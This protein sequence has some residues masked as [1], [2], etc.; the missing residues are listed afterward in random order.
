MVRS[1]KRLASRTLR[2][3]AVVIE[4]IQRA[5]LFGSGQQEVLPAPN[6]AISDDIAIQHKEFTNMKPKR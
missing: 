2:V 6:I 5:R 3:E 4:R 1:R